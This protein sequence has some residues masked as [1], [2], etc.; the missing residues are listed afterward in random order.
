MRPFRFLAFLLVASALAPFASAGANYTVVTS[1][2]P[3]AANDT[4]IIQF[5]VVLDDVPTCDPLNTLLSVTSPSGSNTTYY[6]AFACDVATGIHSFL[7]STGET[8]DYVTQP[9]NDNTAY[10]PS[11]SSEC[12]ITSYKRAQLRVPDSNPALAILVGLFA[13]GFVA[14]LNKKARRQNT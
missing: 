13:A 14:S 1:C 9:F 10:N 7:I 12:H 3:Y 5:R 11:N 2:P 8:G 6:P 4:T